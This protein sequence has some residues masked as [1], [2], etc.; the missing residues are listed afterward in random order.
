ML[1][2][3]ELIKGILVHF[4]LRIILQSCLNMVR[5]SFYLRTPVQSLDKFFIIGDGESL[6]NWLPQQAVAL[7]LVKQSEKFQCVSSKQFVLL[8]NFYSFTADYGQLL[9]MFQ[10]TVNSDSSM[11]I[12]RQSFSV[13][14][15]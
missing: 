10:M 4:L 7:N 2:Y 3:Q 8:N 13:Q 12:E 11:A 6:G 15:M 14:T 9:Q 5:A 1:R